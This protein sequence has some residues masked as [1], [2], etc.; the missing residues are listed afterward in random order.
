M[1]SQT[2]RAKNA[3]VKFTIPINL[4][5]PIAIKAYIN[6]L[7]EPITYVIE[8]N[9]REKAITEEVKDYIL[10]KVKSDPWGTAKTIA[11]IAVT[12]KIIV[13]TDPAI[14]IFSIYIWSAYETFFTQIS[15]RTGDNNLIVG[16][17]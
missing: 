11:T 8:M 15:E 3:R 14:W 10:N 13:E 1:E 2:G 12:R 16:D 7:K 17:R 4:G 6:Q 5:I 9:P